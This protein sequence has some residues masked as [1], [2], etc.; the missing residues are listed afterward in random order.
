MELRGRLRAA[1]ES[2]APPPPP[3]RH[4]LPRPAGA[5]TTSTTA[6]IGTL[7]SFAQRIL[8]EHPIEAGLP[9]LVEV[10]D[11]V[12]SGVAF[13]SRWAALRADMLDDPSLAP[14]CHGPG[15]RD[16]PG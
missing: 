13:D 11:E 6:A 4:P 5:A 12:A 3:A 10:L 8:S 15:R 14:R 1:F 9:P 16:A 7:H 2:C